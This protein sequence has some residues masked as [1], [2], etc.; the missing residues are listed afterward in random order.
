M[1]T[2]IG[3][4]IIK[5]TPM[6]RLTYYMRRGWMALPDDPEGEGYLVEYT[7]GGKPNH[8]DFAGYISW[9]PKDVFENAYQEIKGM[10]FGVAVDAMKLGE[11]VTREGWNGKDMFVYYVPAASYPSQRGAAEAIWGKDTLVPYQAYLALKTSD[12]TVS[13]W[14]PS[15]SDVLADD[16]EIL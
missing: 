6:N 15:I 13:T 11:R 2:F 3:T 10:S 4:K 8:P 5:A 7:D 14:V 1:K 16:W 9:S 12:G